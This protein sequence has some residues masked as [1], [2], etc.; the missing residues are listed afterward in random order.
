MIFFAEIDPDLNITQYT[1][2]TCQYCTIDGYNSVSDSFDIKLLN[3][4]IRSFSKNSIGLTSLLNTLK[5][6][7]N[8]IVL[9]ESWNSDVTVNLCNIDQYT[10]V[11]TVRDSVG[12]GCSVFCR[13]NYKIEKI[14]NLSMCDSDIEVCTA[15][16][17]K[18]SFS[19]IIVGIYRPPS[20]YIDSFLQRTET[21]F[22]G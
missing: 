17:T 12:G 10:G 11:H 15:K 14:D 21:N 20:G 13:D 9:S 4:N 22:I 6:L 19:V 3:Y 1:E 8:F 7:P 18:M 2:N 5:D 16:I